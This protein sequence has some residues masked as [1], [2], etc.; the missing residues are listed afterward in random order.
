MHD[1]RG[2][3][4]TFQHVLAGRGIPLHYTAE[5]WEEDL[6]TLQAPPNP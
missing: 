4:L 6:R 1:G 2:C 5:D 3:R